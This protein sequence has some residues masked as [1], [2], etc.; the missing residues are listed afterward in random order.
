MVFLLQITR[1]KGL[2]GALESSEG[3]F[4]LQAESPL[5][6]MFGFAIELRTATQVFFLS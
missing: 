2:I 6:D 3:W 1:R 4:T 5:N